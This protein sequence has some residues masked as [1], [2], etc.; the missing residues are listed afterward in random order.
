[1]NEL[2]GRVLF[3]AGW[4]VLGAVLRFSFDIFK[5]TQTKSVIHVQGLLVYG[6]VILITGILA[7]ILLDYGWI[8]SLIAGYAGLDLVEGIHNQFKKTKVEIKRKS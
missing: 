5:L 7:G 1:M 4:G 6:S 3:A 8:G 2:V